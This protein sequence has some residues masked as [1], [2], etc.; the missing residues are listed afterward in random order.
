MELE[1]PTPPENFYAGGNGI[2]YAK[3]KYVNNSS[4][5]NQS[6]DEVSTRFEP[7]NK[8]S[9][10][11]IIKLRTNDRGFENSYHLINTAGDTIISRANLSSNTDYYDTLQLDSGCYQLYVEDSGGDGLRWWASNQGNGSL[12]VTNVGLNNP[13]PDSLFL[14]AMEGDFGN[15]MYFHFTI[16]YDMASG[17][18]LVDNSGWTPP[19]STSNWAPPVSTADLLPQVDPY[20]RVYPNPS[21]GL[22]NLEVEGF[23]DVF[24]LDVRNIAGQVVWSEAFEVDLI[25]SRSLD[26]R[27]LPQGIYLLTVSNKDQRFTQRI[28]IR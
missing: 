13:L 22:L 19:D 26:V 9:D 1:L 7:V 12:Q 27:H 23:I 24:Q 10:R 17:N 3:V 8:L 16:D 28:V 20:F 11:F 6:N 2:F 14:M 18:P 25:E 21:N 15:F 4:D 5:Q